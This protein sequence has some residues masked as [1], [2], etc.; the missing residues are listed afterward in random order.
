MAVARGPLIYCLED[1]DN[2]WVEDHFKSLVLDP[3]C[4]ITEKL[5]FDSSISEEPYVALSATNGASLIDTEDQSGPHIAPGAVPY[6]KDRRVDKLHFIPYCLRS[7]RG[8]KGHMR[9]AIRWR[10]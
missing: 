1:F 7:N 5:V 4:T 8:G 10:R 9:V 3:T 2:P 6:R